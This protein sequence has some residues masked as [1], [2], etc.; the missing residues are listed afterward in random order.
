V[1]Y[2]KR[3]PDVSNNRRVL[4]ARHPP[5]VL[6]TR[7]S[8]AIIIILLSWQ[9]TKTVT[10]YTHNHLHLH[11]IFY[12]FQSCRRHLTN[13]S[14]CV[15]VCVCAC[16]C[17]LL[18]RRRYICAHHRNFHTSI[19]K[20]KLMIL[21]STII[22]NRVRYTHKNNPYRFIDECA[23]VTIRMIFMIIICIQPYIL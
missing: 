5:I 22:L 10:C 6:I 3:T 13:T 1:L 9:I 21:Y 19:T 14:V 7:F 12:E 23:T 17:P 4:C 2:F 11:I 8:I 20:R 16:E 18:Y 15:C